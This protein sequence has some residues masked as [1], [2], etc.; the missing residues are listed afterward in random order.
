MPVVEQDEV[1][2]SQGVKIATGQ[3]LKVDDTVKDILDIDADPS[4]TPKQQSPTT[5]PATLKEAVKANEFVEHTH[6]SSSATSTH[7]MSKC[8]A[9]HR[10]RRDGTVDLNLLEST[11]RPFERYQ[12]ARRHL[13]AKRAEAGTAYFIL[14]K[15]HDDDMQTRCA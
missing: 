5:S 3:D 14:A 1:K 7:R 9:R 2:L 12:M 6:T 8:S 15:D 13:E 11:V 10:A 4:P